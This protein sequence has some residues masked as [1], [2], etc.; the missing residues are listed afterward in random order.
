MK[1]ATLATL[2]ALLVVVLSAPIWIEA[3]LRALVFVPDAPLDPAPARIVAEFPEANPELFESIVLDRD[4]SF[5]VSLLTR[6]EVWRVTPEGDRALFATIP[7]GPFRMRDFDGYVGAL[8]LDAEGDL[9]VTV[10]ARDRERRGVWRVSR[11]GDASL[12]AGLATD[13]WPNGIAIG[14]QGGI[15]VADS[16]APRIWRVDRAR[17]DVTLWLEHPLLERTGSRWLPG[18]NGLQVFQGDLYASNT[19]AGTI[20]RIPIRPG[21]DPDAPRVHARGVSADDFA[22]RD[23][24][25]LFLTTHPLNRVLRLSPGGAWSV[26]ATADQGA[27]GPTSAVVGRGRDG[28]D[29]L[30]VLND[31]GFMVPTHRGTPNILALALDPVDAGNSRDRDPRQR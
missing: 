26:L 4:G 22:F 25:E 18:V 6:G 12:F 23:N 30:Y 15:F 17:G 16:A 1:R 31:G 10:G 20:L 11:D 2:G 13:V 14:P 19:S 8:A 27:M 28:R 9:F 3:L 5:Y 7:A 24:G 29:V 21:G